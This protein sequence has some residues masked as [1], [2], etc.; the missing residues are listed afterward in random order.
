MSV[1]RICNRVVVTAT[2]DESI[3]VGARR[4]AQ[5][6]VGTL[7]VLSPDGDGRAGGIV[8]DRDIALRCVA[9]GLDPD[10]H[11][12]SA[13]MT[14]PVRTLSEDSPIEEA[15]LEMAR[16]AVRRLVILGAAGQP[17]GILSLDDV[18]D[19]LIG[20]FGPVRKLLERQAPAPLVVV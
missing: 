19:L 20:E 16:A 5:Y 17:I 6:G 10:Q 11:P 1:G 2:P 15:I 8:T 13:I 4:M 14:H 3:R 18:L 12:L 7:V 9:G